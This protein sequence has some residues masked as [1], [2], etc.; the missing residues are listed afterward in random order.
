MPPANR[1][2]ALKGERR[3]QYRIR[4]NDRWRICVRWMEGDVVQVEIIDYH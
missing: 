1:L 2:E 4:I 3:G